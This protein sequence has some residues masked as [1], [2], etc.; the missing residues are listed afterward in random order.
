MNKTQTQPSVAAQVAGL[1]QLPM[2]ELWALWDRFYPHRPHSKTN[3]DYLESRIAYKLQE[4]AYGGLSQET[5]QR[6]IAI[7][8]KHSKI[9][10]RRQSKEI[11]LAPGTVLV[12]EHGQRDHQV[13][14]TAE[15][16]FEYEGKT[17]RSLSAVARHITGT[18]WNGPLFFGLRK[19]G[20]DA[21]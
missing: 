6:L 19:N 10:P 14:V 20:E 16:L 12:R 5:R 17:Y 7:G 15:G 11:Y 18:Q 21:R 13:T 1:P 8:I 2:Q 3:R 4:E 9:K